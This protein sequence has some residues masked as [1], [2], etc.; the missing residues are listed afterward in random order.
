MAYNV[1]IT[2]PKT[3]EEN[4][5]FLKQKLEEEY[6]NNTTELMIA[7]SYGDLFTCQK[8]IK[9]AGKTN[10]AGNTALM[11]ACGSGRLPVIQLLIEKEDIRLRNI[12]GASGVD[13]AFMAR[14][15]EACSF[16][17]TYCIQHNYHE[18]KPVI[19]S[20]KQG[21]QQAVQ[22]LKSDYQL[23]ASD[24]YPESTNSVNQHKQLQTLK[25]NCGTI[26]SKQYK[27]CT[28]CGKKQ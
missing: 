15:F 9:E 7:A 26:I 8:R 27:F 1:K 6:P 25:C 28:G 10:S 14:R 19:R 4:E 22:K 24:M 23:E 13:M 2:I 16:L 3:F 18:L 11:Y 12:K 5:Q 21:E 20:T 17:E